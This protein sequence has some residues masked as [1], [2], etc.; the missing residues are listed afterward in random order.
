MPLFTRSPFA[1]PPWKPVRPPRPGSVRCNVCGW[2]G[3]AFEGPVHCEGANCPGCGA[4]TRDRFLHWCAHWGAPRPRRSRVLENSPRL[5]DAYRRAMGRWYRYAASDYDESAH[6]G[7]IRLDLQQIDLPDASLDLVLSAHVLEHVPDTDAALRELRRVVAPGGR[8]VLQVP[9]LQGA[10][11]P[12]EEP[13]FHGDNTPV[14]WRFGFDLTDRLRAVGFT[15]RLA[16]VAGFVDIVDPATRPRREDVSGEFDVD[17][18]AAGVRPDDLV[19]VADT[20][21]AAWLG[22][23]PPYQLLTWIC[24]VPA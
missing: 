3:A 1:R 15:T 6:R 7:S 22:L 12:P 9:V 20:A 24:D 17:S 14:F 13:E 8:L 23:A 18:M 16:C 5:G 11:A 4:I 2:T 10:T 19:V 21:Q